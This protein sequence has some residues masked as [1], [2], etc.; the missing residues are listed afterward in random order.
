MRSDCLCDPNLPHRPRVTYTAIPLDTRSP[1]RVSERAP[2]RHKAVPLTCMTAPSPP[3]PQ[4]PI[5]APGH[6]PGADP[7]TAP[8]ATPGTDP[9][10]R[11]IADNP[12]IDLDAVNQRF[13]DRAQRVAAGEI[14]LEDHALDV[15]DWAHRRFADGLVMSSSFGAQSAL[16]LH[17]ATRVAPDI[18]V[19]L[20]DTGYLFAQTY[21]FADD[22]RQRLG[23]NLKVYTP[24]ITA[25]MLEALHG[26]LWESEDGLTRYH[27]ITKV[28]PMQRA[29]N[30]LNATAWLAG[31]RANQTDHRAQLPTL[32]LQDGAYKIHPVLAWTTRDVH[33]YLTRH[34]LPY[35]PL[36][37]QGYAS[38]GDWHSSAPITAAADPNDPDHEKA[39]RATRFS[40][41]KQECGLHL[42]T[43]PEEAASRD[44]SAL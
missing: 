28:E 21:R 11:A 3:Q 20:I 39:V 29:L 17:L 27:Q 23:L 5:D 33:D 12:L 26:K 1:I 30:D 36:Y 43:T 40:G 7:G 24:R 34:D 35:H 18:P 2:I 15:I 16:M 4:A 42:P 41:L 14:T 38:I 22:L 37:E 10:T 8:G 19:V 32:G 9:G 31:L 25:G 13:A 6:T 44:S